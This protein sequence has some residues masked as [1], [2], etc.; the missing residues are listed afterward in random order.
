MNQSIGYTWSKF[1]PFL[2]LQPI[3]QL[4]D[5]GFELG[6]VGARFQTPLAVCQ[7]RLQI[8][9]LSGQSEKKSSGVSGEKVQGTGGGSSGHLTQ[10]HASR[11]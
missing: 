4:P 7:P 9:I 8:F 1:V 10:Q 3:L 2:R 6:R 5:S 11:F